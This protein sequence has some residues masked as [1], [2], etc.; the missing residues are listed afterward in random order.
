[1]SVKNLFFKLVILNILLISCKD[2]QK[3]HWSYEGESSPQH[4]EELIK[5]SDCGG[6]HQSPINIISTHIKD[7]VPNRILELQ[8]S[9]ETKLIGAINNGHTLQINF[10]SGDSLK[11]EGDTYHL[12]QVHFHEPSEHTFDGIRYPIEIHLVNMSENNEFTV[13]SILGKEGEKSHLMAL[14]DEILPLEKGKEKKIDHAAD[15]GDLAPATM[16][17]YSYTGSLTTPPCTENINWVIFKEPVTLSLDEVVA[18]KKIMPL[19]NF[20]DEQPIND[21]IVTLHTE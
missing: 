20:R 4:W 10:E 19:N 12:K 1:M 3:K 2:D 16:D 18:I 5:N 7:T 17:F 15:L 21:R 11:F 8:Y 14:L 6:K 9:P 13:L